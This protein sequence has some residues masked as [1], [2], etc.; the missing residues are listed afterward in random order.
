MYNNGQ[1]PGHGQVETT[2]IIREL[3]EITPELPIG[4]IVQGTKTAF[5]R[6]AHA[7]RGKMIDEQAASIESAVSS[8]RVYHSAE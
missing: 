4:K 2:D 3:T 5:T 1:W 7:F 8:Q 6:L